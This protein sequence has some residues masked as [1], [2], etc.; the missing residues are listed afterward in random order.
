MRNPELKA[1][2]A[3]LLLC[4]T[5]AQAADAPR[6]KEAKKIELKA[7]EGCQIDDRTQG[8]VK[9]DACGRWWCGYTDRKD[10][11]EVWPTFEQDL[12]CTWRL[13]GEHCKCRREPA[14]APAKKKK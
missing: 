8:I 12:H 11:T 1:A 7:G 14:P 10:I 9:Q 2:L 13:E 3:A 4:C 5:A 6:D